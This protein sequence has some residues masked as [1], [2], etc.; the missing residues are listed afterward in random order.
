MVSDGKMALEII[1]SQKYDVIL[2]DIWGVVLL[3][4]FSGLSGRMNNADL[5]KA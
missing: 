4:S 2:C 3:L 5:I 1:R